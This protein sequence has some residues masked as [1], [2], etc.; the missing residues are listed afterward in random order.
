MV[1][2]RKKLKDVLDK[3]GHYIVYIR[4]DKRFRCPCFI[5][6]SGEPHSDCPMCFGT[7]YKVQIEKIRTRRK[8]SSVPESLIGVNRLQSTGTMAP[9]S[10]TYYYEHYVQPKESDLILEVLWD[11]EGVPRHIKN[12]YLVSAVDPQLGYKGRV[13]FYQVYCRFDRKGDHDDNSLS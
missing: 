13:E 12:K 7:G 9:K 6:R 2:F 11:K 4:C 5:E 1:D 10:Y 8:I 3:Y